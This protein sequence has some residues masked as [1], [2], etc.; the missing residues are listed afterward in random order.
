MQFF[1]LCYLIQIWLA[2]SR[3]PSALQMCVAKM[4]FSS[5]LWLT[6]LLWIQSQWIKR[7]KIQLN[8]CGNKRE[9]KQI[10]SCAVLSRNTNVSTT[11]CLCLTLWMSVSISPV[12]LLDWIFLMSNAWFEVMC[13]FFD[14]QLIHLFCS[15]QHFQ[16]LKW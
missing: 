4:Y 5:S 15:E 14:W 11:T 7:V 13:L 2:T 12:S 10:K 9:S 6:H 1:F 3:S 8:C 16:Y